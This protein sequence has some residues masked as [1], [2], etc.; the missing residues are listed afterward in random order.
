MGLPWQGVD[1]HEPM[2][3]LFVIESVPEAIEKIMGRN[4]Q[5]RQII[6]NGWVQLALLSPTG[7]ELLLYRKGQ[8]EPYSL[9][10]EHLPH[11]ASSRE[12]YRGVRE[13]LEFC[14]LTG[15]TGTVSRP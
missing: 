1:I 14:E 7:D 12:W 15:A 13:H 8:F 10:A 5:V 4:E 6:S 9:H 11:A 3:L 2:R